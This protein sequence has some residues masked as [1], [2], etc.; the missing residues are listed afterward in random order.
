MRW[1]KR[2]LYRLAMLHVAAPTLRLAGRPVI[3]FLHIGKT[4]GTAVKAAFGAYR[5]PIRRVPR[6][7]LLFHSHDV[8]LRHLP[9]REPV[10]LFVRDP[11]SRFVSSFNSRLRRG[12]PR[13]HVPWTRAEA[14]AFAEFRTPN[15]LAEALSTEDEGLRERA[16][17]AMQAIEHV[18]DPL[19]D[20]LGTPEDLQA[21]RADIVFVGHQETFDTDFDKLATALG[22]ASPPARPG[23]E[24]AHRAPPQSDTTLSARARDNLERWYAPDRALIAWLESPADSCP[25]EAHND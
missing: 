20:F 12:R 11:V 7:F 17:A 6:G 2:R 24:Q 10:V 15:E 5:W 4:G 1:L 19:T 22:L 8:R 3:H 9:P 25:A 23:R 16:S 18:A 13:R 21:R 14:R